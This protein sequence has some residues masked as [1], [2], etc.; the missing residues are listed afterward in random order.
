MK[1]MP[2]F[3]AVNK[4]TR[5]RNYYFCAWFDTS[6]GKKAALI[7]EEA[8]RGLQWVNQNKF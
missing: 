1:V 7:A 6:G 4:Q 8:V 2:L 3:D 5:I